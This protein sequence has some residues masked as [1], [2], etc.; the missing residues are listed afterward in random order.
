M[1]VLFLYPAWDGIGHWTLLIMPKSYMPRIIVT[2]NETDL[3]QYMYFRSALKNLQCKINRHILVGT[4]LLFTVYYV[5][6][7]VHPNLLVY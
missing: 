5:Q 6:C 1:F 3:F 7:N 4:K 2:K